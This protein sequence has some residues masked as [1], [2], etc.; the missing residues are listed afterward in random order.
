MNFFEKMLYS[1]VRLHTQDITSFD[2]DSYDYSATGFFMKLTLFDNDSSS[3]CL[4][5]NAHVVR[6]QRKI[7]F[8]LHQKN[9]NGKRSKTKFHPIEVYIY[10]NTIIDNKNDIAIVNITEDI[11]EIEKT[12]KN[13][14]F[15]YAVDE[16]D[17][18]KKESLLHHFI[19]EDVLMVGCPNNNWDT[20]NHLPFALKGSIASMPYLNFDGDSKFIVNIT[21]F[22]GSSGSPI[23]LYNHESSIPNLL[24]IM[25]QEVYKSTNTLHYAN[26]TDLEIEDSM[27][28]NL[29]MNIA[30]SAKACD[31]LNLIR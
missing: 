26:G 16:N 22:N 2:C 30:I 9:K 20:V 13:K 31:I 7:K 24:G 12:I 27:I 18:I 6:N 28:V 3:L 1:T 17:I 25:C 23:F 5:T 21:A 19:G 29:P 14:L 15:Y 10:S 8:V 11:F 4:V